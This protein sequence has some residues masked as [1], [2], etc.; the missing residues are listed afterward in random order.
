MTQEFFPFELERMMS[1]WE[2]QVEYNLSESGV[3]P[4]TLQ[5]LF[6][7][8]DRKWQELLSTPLNYPQTNGDQ[9]LRQSIAALYPHAS[10]DNVIGNGRCYPG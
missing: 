1:I 4:L 6:L 10:P 2:N 9:D 7:D 5:E 8:D 3:H